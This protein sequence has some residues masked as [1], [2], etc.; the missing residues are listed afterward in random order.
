MLAPMNHSILVKRGDVERT[1]Q[2]S[3]DLRMVDLSEALLAIPEFVEAFPAP[4]PSKVTILFGD[5]VTS[6][7][8]AECEE[9]TVAEM[10][11]DFTLVC[12]AAPA[13]A[14]PPMEMHLLKVV[15]AEGNEKVV[16]QVSNNLKS[17]DLVL[18]MEECFVNLPDLLEYCQ[19]LYPAKKEGLFRALP[20]PWA[21][22]PQE[23]LSRMQE[24]VAKL[25]PVI[26]PIEPTSI[27]QCFVEVPKELL[28]KEVAGSDNEENDDNGVAAAELQKVELQKVEMA[29]LLKQISKYKSSEIV[30]LKCC[31]MTN[32]GEECLASFEKQR[33]TSKPRQGNPTTTSEQV[34]FWCNLCADEFRLKDS[35]HGG[36]L[37]HLCGDAHIKKQLETELPSMSSVDKNDQADVLA[38][39]LPKCY[40]KLRRHN[41]S[42]YQMAVAERETKDRFRAAVTAMTTPVGGGGS[43]SAPSPV[44]FDGFAAAAA[45]GI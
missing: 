7:E 35:A 11:G 12:I 21:E 34:M 23:L 16:L 4:P 39:Q 10:G 24:I 3:G 31:G 25:P 30:M 1:L 42:Q 32:G 19:L 20:N 27:S 18:K 13:P 6:C 33:Y 43:G 5:G 44:G 8:L 17:K 2:L 29:S 37:R 15:D 41:T 9:A 36:T 38:H 40:S 26:R 22:G 14:A 28:L 45:E